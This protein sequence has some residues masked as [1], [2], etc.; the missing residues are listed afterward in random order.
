MCRLTAL[1]AVLA[2]HNDLLYQ[3]ETGHLLRFY[4]VGTLLLLSVAIFL[5]IAIIYVS[6]LGTIADD[7]PRVKLSRLLYVRTALLFPDLVWTAVGTKWAFKDEAGTKCPTDAVA[8]VRS[9][10]VVSWLLQLAFIVFIVLFFDPLGRQHSNEQSSSVQD[11]QQLW[12]KRFCIHCR[13]VWSV[14][15][16]VSSLKMNFVFLF[17]YACKNF[18]VSCN[19]CPLHSKRV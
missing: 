4:Y 3:C 18:F 1:A 7:R 10:L 5:C 9:V 19:I 11:S 8:V 14:I 13:T 16:S 2:A 12:K 6:A 15:K 17:N